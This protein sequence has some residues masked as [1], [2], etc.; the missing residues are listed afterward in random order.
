MVPADAQLTPGGLLSVELTDL[1]APE[2]V[3]GIPPWQD[4]HWLAAAEDWIDAACARAA[5][6]RTG[7]AQAR[8]RPYSVVARVPTDNGT[9][10]FKANPPASRFEPA[11][12][13]ALAAWQPDRFTVPIA[14]DLDR[15]WSLTRDGG[16]TL[17]DEQTST[18]GTGA[19]QAALRVYGQLQLDLARH[20]DD[21]L[22]LGLADLRP[23]SVPAQFEE[24]LDD[25]V[26]EQV[27]DVPDGIT[28]GQYQALR[29]LAPRLRAWCA[30]L[31][32]LGVPAS[33]DHADVHPHNI[34]ATT[35]TPF[36]WGDAAIA[37]PFSSLWV[38]LRT[39][40]E[41]LSPPA[42]SSELDT[43]TENYFKPWLE[44]GHKRRALTRSLSLALRT[45]PLARALTWGRLFP[46]YLGHPEP[47]AHAAK[48]LAAMLKPDPLAL[49][50]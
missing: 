31:E 42:R 34:F 23:G 33:L 4:Q 36:D 39:A 16:P 32:D 17:R 2:P 5:L 20:A 22:A 10:W 3:R 1:K 18:G 15:A 6:T 38:A 47:A 13:A 48:V 21:M 45:A 37:H 30:E 25:S 46:C 50:D 29:A 27:I 12:L 40:G 19:W 7:P 35:S 11:L 44:A 8:G 49:P 26:T 41:H 28:R 24:L 14:V 9:V 43:L